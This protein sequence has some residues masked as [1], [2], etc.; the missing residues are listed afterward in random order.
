MVSFLDAHSHNNYRYQQIGL[1]TGHALT[2]LSLAY[3]FSSSL[4]LT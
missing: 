3:D 2:G 4:S 1:G